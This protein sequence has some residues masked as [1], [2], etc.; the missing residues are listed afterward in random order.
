MSLMSEPRILPLPSDAF[1]ALRD[2][3]VAGRDKGGR[4]DSGSCADSETSGSE[5]NMTDEDEDVGSW[6]EG[7][8]QG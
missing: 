5:A 7:R 1:D 2:M 8:F 6:V 3:P 4:R